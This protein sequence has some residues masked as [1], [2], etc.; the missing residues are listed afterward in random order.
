MPALFREPIFTVLD[1]IKARLKCSGYLPVAGYFRCVLVLS[2]ETQ[3][4]NYMP[5]G[6]QEAVV[7]V[8]AEGQD[9]ILTY[10]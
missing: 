5:R 2:M 7:A 9:G 4:K 1:V 8:S 10:S 6:R 3:F